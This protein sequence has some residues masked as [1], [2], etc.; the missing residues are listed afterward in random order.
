MKVSEIT[1]WVRAC[2][3]NSTDPVVRNVFHAMA[4]GIDGRFGF[5]SEA[6]GVGQTRSLREIFIE[7]IED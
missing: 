6:I 3:E 2:G 5:N 4:S 7:I 1:N